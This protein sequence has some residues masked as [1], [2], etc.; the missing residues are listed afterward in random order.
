MD[1]MFCGIVDIALVLIMLIVCIVG[2]KKGF[3]QKAIGLV[4]LV[5]A[6]A[7]AFCFCSQL[8]ELLKQSGIIYPDIYEKIYNNVIASEVLADQNATIIDVLVSLDIPKFLAQLVSNAIG[9]INA[10]AIAV[11]ISTYV[12]DILMNIISFVALFLGVFIG[13]LLLK[14]ISAILRGNAL[15]RFVDG[16]LGMALYGCIFVAIVYSL[17]AVLHL[18]MDQTWFVTVKE[19]LVV[20]MKLEEDTFRLSKYI[21]ENNI[22]LN[23]INM[24]F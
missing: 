7:V 19:F 14:L 23:I 6:I 4:S 8:S 22:V 9:E 12:S 13:A 2:Y 3:L 15:I 17:F 18:C 1:L 10:A 11:E 5:V 16:V 20:D 24:L 21:Y